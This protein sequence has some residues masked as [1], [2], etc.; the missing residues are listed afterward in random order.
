MTE[1]MNQD[2]DADHH[3][4]EKNVLQNVEAHKK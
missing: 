3:Q 2:H 4:R 1:L